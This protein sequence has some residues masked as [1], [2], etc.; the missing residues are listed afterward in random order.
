[1]KWAPAMGNVLSYEKYMAFSGLVA[2]DTSMYM[3]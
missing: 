2:G 1:M 3:N